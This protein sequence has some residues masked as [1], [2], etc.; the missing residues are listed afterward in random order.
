MKC[1]KFSLL[2]CIS[3]PDAGEGLPGFTLCVQILLIRS[4]LSCQLKLSTIPVTGLSD[5]IR[6]G[7]ELDNAN[8]HK[9]FLE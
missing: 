1:I 9:T 2:S 8:D 4:L 3:R 5:D 6:D 7:K